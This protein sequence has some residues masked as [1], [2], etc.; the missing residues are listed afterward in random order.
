MASNSSPDLIWAVIRNNNTNIVKRNH[1]I[2]NR[3]AGNV[4][5]LNTYKYS[6]LANKRSVTLQETTD[7]V[8]IALGSGAGS[9][10]K[11]D[12]R[13]GGAS[14]QKAVGKYRPDLQGD[15][16]ARFQALKKVQARPATAAPT[17]SRRRNAKK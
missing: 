5:N 7:G 13:R 15:A 3:E 14:V 16:K 6:Q 8:Q 1:V 9:V 10:S 4:K 2:F 17:K 12:G 11:K